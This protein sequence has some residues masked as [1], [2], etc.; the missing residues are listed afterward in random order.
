MSNG[1]TKFS[2]KKAEKIIYPIIREL[3]RL[4]KV[5]IC[6]SYRRLKAEV[7]DIDLVGDN[8]KMIGCLL[9][10]LN[11]YPINEGDIAGRVSVKGLQIDLRIAKKEAW[12]TSL[13]MWTGSKEENIRLRSIAKDRGLKLNE[14]GLWKGK[15]N[16]A[17]RKTE[18]QIYNLLGEKYLEPV[19]R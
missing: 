8:P 3:N 13:M 9:N 17:K 18:E 16:I 1:T 5:E 12:G 14:Y 4:G 2:R 15:R 19:E 10:I 6:G 7:G 11:T